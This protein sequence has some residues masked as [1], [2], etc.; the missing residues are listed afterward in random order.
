MTE[1]LEEQLPSV[2]HEVENDVSTEG[3]WAFVSSWSTSHCI[4][5][6]VDYQEQAIHDSHAWRS[7]KPAGYRHKTETTFYD[8]ALWHKCKVK[9][10]RGDFESRPPQGIL[11]R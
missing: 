10:D 6:P 2:R 3:E 5:A 8:G 9:F 7:S 11:H 1:L 4:G